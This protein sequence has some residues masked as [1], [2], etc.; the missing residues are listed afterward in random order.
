MVEGR[1]D[2]YKFER[3]DFAVSQV[4]VANVANIVANVANVANVADIVANVANVANVVNVVANVANVTFITFKITF[5]QNAFLLFLQP[6][7]V[8]G[9]PRTG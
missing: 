2:N 1:V 5:F 3:N 9:G 6:Q 7:S 8:C 4:L